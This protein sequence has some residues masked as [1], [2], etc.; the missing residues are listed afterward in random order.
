MGMATFNPLTDFERMEDPYLFHSF[1]WPNDRFYCKQY[2][3]IDSVESNFMTVAVAGNK[4]GKDYVAG[5]IVPKFFLCGQGTVRVICT[6]V[7]QDHLDV[8]RSE[9]QK[10]LETSQVPLIYP[11]GPLI[12]NDYELRKIYRGREC[13]TSYVKF[14]VSK[15]GEG[16]S[17]HHADRTL[18]VVDEASGADNKVLEYSAGWMKKGLLLGNPKPCQNFFREMVQKGDVLA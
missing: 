12:V 11:R 9:V 2:E 16:M 4:L 8:L 1:C 3:V 18:L 5:F 17:G 13:E 15:K 10:R 7:R 14:T 6:S